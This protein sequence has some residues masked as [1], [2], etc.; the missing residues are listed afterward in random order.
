MHPMAGIIWMKKSR[1]MLDH[2]QLVIP[3]NPGLEVIDRNRLVGDLKGRFLKGRVSMNNHGIK[4]LER[5]FWVLLKTN[6]SKLHLTG[7]L[8]VGRLHFYTFFC[9]LEG[10]NK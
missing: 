9:R 3:R 6:N 4:T 8:E 7:C 1:T 2:Q 10:L 5:F